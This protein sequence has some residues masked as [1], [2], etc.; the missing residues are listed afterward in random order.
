M[1][2]AHARQ[3]ALH[4]E[5]VVAPAVAVDDAAKLRDALAAA[6]ADEALERAR[7][8]EDAGNALRERLV[9]FGAGEQSARHRVA[10]RVSRRVCRVT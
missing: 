8:L 10:R 2:G 6:R 4:A 9:V 5:L 1:R 7:A 3:G